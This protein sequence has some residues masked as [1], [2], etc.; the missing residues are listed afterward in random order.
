MPLL[1]KTFNDVSVSL[2]TVAVTNPSTAV[3]RGAAIYG[4]LLAGDTNKH[5]RDLLILS[6]KTA[7]DNTRVVVNQNS[8]LALKQQ[9]QFTTSEDNQTTVVF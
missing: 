1:H 5:L 8:T 3:V 4:G 7:D 9:R 6:F 2:N